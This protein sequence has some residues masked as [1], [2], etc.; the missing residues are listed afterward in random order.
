[1]SSPLLLASSFL[2][3]Q[4]SAV[5]TIVRL[6]AANLLTRTLTPY[7]I[8]SIRFF[9]DQ[10]PTGAIVPLSFAIGHQ[11]GVLISCGPWGLTDNFVAIDSLSPLRQ[12]VTEQG[13]YYLWRFPR[14]MHV[15]PGRALSIQAKLLTALPA[16]HGIT[17]HVAASGVAYDKNE[18]LPR[19][20]H[21]PFASYWDTRFS[22]SVN[23][24]PISLRNP[25]HKTIQVHSLIGRPHGGD[26]TTID[27][28]AS[29]QI[30]RHDGVGIS[31]ERLR[32]RDIFPMESRMIPFDDEIPFNGKITVK[33][34]PPSAGNADSFTTVGYLA[35]RVEEV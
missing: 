35:D 4:P 15:P 22:G 18:T 9:F 30:F 23:N 2:I 11:V 5:G 6:P 24:D 12:T 1:M 17:L 19:V 34:V 25:I 3:P 28:A 32:F 20:T 13:G 14:R 16:D 29:T 31:D 27:Q 33:F 21:V 8:D 10:T 7:G 26:L